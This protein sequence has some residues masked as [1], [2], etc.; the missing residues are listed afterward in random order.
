MSSDCTGD[1]RVNLLIHVEAAIIELVSGGSA[2]YSIG[3]RSFTYIN[4]NDLIALRDK[5]K[6]ELYGGIAINYATFKDC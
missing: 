3:S 2:S 5:I 1:F 4:L 6:D